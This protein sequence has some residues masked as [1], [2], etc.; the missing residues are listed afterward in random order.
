MNSSSRKIKSNP[1]VVASEKQLFQ[2]TL[3]NS[4]ISISKPSTEMVNNI[5]N[6]TKSLE[7]INLISI[8]LMEI[9]EAFQP[10]SEIAVTKVKIERA[11]QP[12]TKILDR[13]PSTKE[14]KEAFDNISQI[15]DDLEKVSHVSKN[16]AS[17][18]KDNRNL[19]P[20][21]REKLKRIEEVSSQSENNLNFYKRIK[22]S[23][24]R[25]KDIQYGNTNQVFINCPFDL[26]YLRMFQSIVFT[27]YDCGF[28]PR[29]AR[30][31]DDS[32]EVRLTK[33]V[34]LIDDCRYGIHDISRVELDKI[35]KLP[36][37]NMP[38]ELG[39]F[40]GLK[41]KDEMKKCLVL[42]K[43]KYRY[44]K[45]LSDIAGGDIYGHD[46]SIDEV[47]KS[48]RNWLV[49]NSKRVTIPDYKT[50]TDRYYEFEKEFTSMYESKN[51]ILQ[52]ITYI[53]LCYHI[54]VWLQSG[55]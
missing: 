50:I 29:C 34:K 47:I 27:I 4:I 36:R 19:S 30:E 38:F 53:E 9:R 11:L 40:F 12:I 52:E 28:I 2:D 10:L 6:V 51:I 33:I 21:I 22:Q 14:L 37:F 46:N 26:E 1:K 49:T 54:E 44:R 25:K 5:D 3:R 41:S 24:P 17:S 35:T 42:D 55:K 15:A 39:I 16:I 20:N 18:F 8:P 7:H 48:I 32:S 13:T 31:E 45:S 43:D 23:K